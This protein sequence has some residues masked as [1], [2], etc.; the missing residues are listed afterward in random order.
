M[1]SLECSSRFAYCFSDYIKDYSSHNLTALNHFLFHLFVLACTNFHEVEFSFSNYLCSFISLVIRF[2]YNSMAASVH[3]YN[4]LSQISERGLLTTNF[5]KILDFG[6][7][8]TVQ[9]GLCIQMI[10]SIYLHS[11]IVFQ[12][13]FYLIMV[14]MFRGVYEISFTVVNRILT[15]GAFFPYKFK[16]HFLTLWTL[17]IGFGDFYLLLNGYIFHLCLLY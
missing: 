5:L 17:H 12:L 6:S 14:W 10:V 16:L 11:I 7:S 13:F 2:H 1:D 9:Y 15:M 3:F 4:I 8:L